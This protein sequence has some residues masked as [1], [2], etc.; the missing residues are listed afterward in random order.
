MHFSHSLVL[1]SMDKEKVTEKLKVG[2]LIL[3]VTRVG[4]GGKSQ[5]SS[6]Y[7][8]VTSGINNLSSRAF[9]SITTRQ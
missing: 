4:K 1:Q 8:H 2:M 9:N 7:V 6:D 3:S 5:E